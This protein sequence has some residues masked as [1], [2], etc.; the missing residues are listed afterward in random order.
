MFEVSAVN[1]FLLNSSVNKEFILFPKGSI[2]DA[3][4][5]IMKDSY[6]LPIFILVEFAF[7]AKIP[8]GIE[9]LSVFMLFVVL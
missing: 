7:P 3:V 9:I 4:M 5:L 1:P 2:D 6:M 8:A